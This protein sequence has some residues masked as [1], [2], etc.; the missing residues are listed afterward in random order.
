VLIKQVM[1]KDFPYYIDRT[2]N[3]Q[4]TITL[5]MLTFTF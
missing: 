5:A 4:R 1:I 2:V 3:F